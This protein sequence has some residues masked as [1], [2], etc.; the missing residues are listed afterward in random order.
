[1]KAFLSFYNSSV[2][3]K[4]T[5][6]LTGLFLTIFLIEHLIGNL[7]VLLQDGGAAFETY[8]EFLTSNPYA[9]L[10]LRFVEAILFA[11]IIL[12]AWSGFT[13]WLK[14]KRARLTKYKEYGIAENTKFASRWTAG[15]AL[16]VFLFLVIH[17]KAFFWNIRLSGEHVSGYTIA[18][19]TFSN[20]YYTWFY[21]FSFIVLGYHLYHGF[22][23][24]FQTLGLKTKKYSTLIETIAVVFWCII[25]L[26]F[27]L[28]PIYIL[29]HPTTLAL[30]K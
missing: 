14:N 4:M 20:P 7:L 10:P 17:L 13:V 19:Q 15:T 21:V 16:L 25:P 12:H 9:Y 3:R 29:F 22:Q 30:A 28:I 1:M 8:S 5:M 24:A 27:A 23:S 18:H 26:G 11:S 6:S 2:G